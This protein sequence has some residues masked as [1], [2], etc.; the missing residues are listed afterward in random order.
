MFSTN[1]GMRKVVTFRDS[2]TFNSHNNSLPLSAFRETRTL[3]LTKVRKIGHF[4]VLIARKSQN[5][6]GI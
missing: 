2:Q 5:G 1:V 6:F 4:E 3:E